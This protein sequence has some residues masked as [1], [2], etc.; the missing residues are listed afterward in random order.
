MY[1]IDMRDACESSE[2]RVGFKLPEIC[3]S[4]KKTCVI[5][6]CRCMSSNLEMC[7]IQVGDAYE[8]HMSFK[9]HPHEC[10][11]VIQVGGG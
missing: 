2:R 11:C 6:I 4:S 9:L 3:H 10:V 7:V 8:M 5:E 1:V